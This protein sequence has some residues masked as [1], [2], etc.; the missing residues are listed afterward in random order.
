MPSLAIREGLV[1]TPSRIPNSLA[2]LIWA[3][4]AVSMKNFI[5][6]RFEPLRYYRSKF[7]PAISRAA[8]ALYRYFGGFFFQKQQKS[9]CGRLYNTN[10]MYEK[11]LSLPD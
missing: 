6:L 2:S 8:L 7:N 5:F 9:C 3:R 1:V 4:L 11:N 10:P